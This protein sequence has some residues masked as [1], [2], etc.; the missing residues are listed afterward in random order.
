MTFSSSLLLVGN[1]EVESKIACVVMKHVELTEQGSHHEHHEHH[2]KITGVKISKI[3]RPWKMPLNA[4]KT[5]ALQIYNALRLRAL[6]V[7]CA[8]QSRVCLMD[9]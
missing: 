4:R 8:S 3:R 6:Q 2:H 7:Q 9:K 1:V 5:S